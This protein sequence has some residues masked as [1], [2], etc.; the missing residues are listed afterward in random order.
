[1]LPKNI[2]SL[3]CVSGSSYPVASYDIYVWLIFNF[4]N[5]FLYFCVN[6]W[7]I[8]VYNVHWFTLEYIVS[9]IIMTRI[10]SLWFLQLQKQLNIIQLLLFLK[11]LRRFINPRRTI[12]IE[13]EKR[14]TCSWR[15]AK[16]SFWSTPPPLNKTQQ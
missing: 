8:C 6:A 12:F 1:M 15:V 14:W 11:S 7:A 4:V 9:D 13:P 10:Q 2:L 3:R 16:S 5:L